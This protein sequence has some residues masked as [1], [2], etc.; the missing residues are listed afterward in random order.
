MIHFDNVS[1]TYP[2]GSQAL[3]EINLHLSS[4]SMSFITGRTG[5][6][7]TT[8]I[9]LIMAMLRPSRGKLVVGDQSINRISLREVPPYRR[10]I[11]LIFQDHQLLYDRSVY[12]NVAMPLHIAGFD[13]EQIKRRVL[14]ALTK[15]HLEKKL[16]EN[17][18]HL[19]VGEQQRVCIARAIISRPKILL[20]DEPT[21]N[22]DHELSVDIIRMFLD[23]N[24]VGTTVLVA[25]HDLSLIDR[26]P[27]NVIQLGEGRLLQ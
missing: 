17:P 4:G 7:K 9:R 18:I 8:L 12:E 13:K 27:S 22:L 5:A 23:F 15:V 10:Q 26:F 19:S 3:K 14:A 6:G 1:L 11:G 21:G 25:T 24:S 2:N 20:A 16:A